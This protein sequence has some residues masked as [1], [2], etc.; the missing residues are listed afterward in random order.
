MSRFF[1]PLAVLMAVASLT[2]SGCALWPW[3]KK[4]KKP[5]SSSHLYEGNAPSLH[6]NDKPEAAGG[7]FNPS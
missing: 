6:F 1:L 3:G 4:D 7:E 2:L 5:A